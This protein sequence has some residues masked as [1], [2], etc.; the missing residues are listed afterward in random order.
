MAPRGPPYMAPRHSRPRSP[1]REGSVTPKPA[2]GSGGDPGNA[3]PGSPSSAAAAPGWF[4]RPPPGVDAGGDYGVPIVTG[5]AGGAHTGE[6]ASAPAW[7]AIARRVQAEE[8]AREVAISDLTAYVDQAKQFLADRIEAVERI[9]DSAVRGR[10]SAGTQ[11]DGTSASVDIEVFCSQQEESMKEMAERCEDFMLSQVNMSRD[12]EESFRTISNSISAQSSQVRAITAD[13]AAMGRELS[14]RLGRVESDCRRLDETVSGLLQ[15]FSSIVHSS[16]TQSIR[17]VASACDLTEGSSLA[18]LA[19]TMDP[20][21][22]AIVSTPPRLLNHAHL[23]RTISPPRHRVP[24]PRSAASPGRRVGVAVPLAALPGMECAIAQ[25][26]PARHWASVAD[27]TPS[28]G[29]M[30]GHNG[31]MQPAHGLS[32]SLT[33][34]SGGQLLVLPT[35]QDSRQVSQASTSPP[36]SATTRQILVQPS[37]QG[38]APYR[39]SPRRVSPARR[40]AS[41]EIKRIQVSVNSP[42]APPLGSS[43][44]SSRATRSLA[45]PPPLASVVL[46]R[47]GQSS[48]QGSLGSQASNTSSP[49]CPPHRTAAEQPT[50]S[51]SSSYG[52]SATFGIGG[53]VSATPGETRSSGGSFTAAARCPPWAAPHLVV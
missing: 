6:I 53:S 51:T 26:G 48:S 30:R 10:S 11:P 50:S 20:E 36:G 12:Y 31:D 9:A 2:H 34:P 1:L 43:S 39:Q 24:L 38:L 52:G 49:P 4:E 21:A 17:S 42:A 14:A 35:L 28:P 37:R 40:A 13:F 41:S 47:L 23:L 45:A 16:L 27:R 29:A 5:F 25:A 15:D 33:A 44:M 32:R 8:F 18:D 46:T 19:L 7:A 22:S 3:R